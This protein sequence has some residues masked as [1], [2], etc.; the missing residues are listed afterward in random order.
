MDNMQDKLHDLMS[1]N[2]NQ[3][4]SGGN[5]EPLSSNSMYNAASIAGG[6]NKKGKK[7]GSQCKTHKKRGNTHG[8]RSHRKKSNKNHNKS[9]KNHNKSN[10]KHKKYKK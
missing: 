5:P 4:Q 1:Q 6:K 10:K 2:Q 8:G 9:N 3:N 7:C